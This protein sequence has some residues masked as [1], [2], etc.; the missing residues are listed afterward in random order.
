MTCSGHDLGAAY[1][2]A[3][4]TNS[5]CGVSDPAGRRISGA[6]PLSDP[7]SS[8][9]SNIPANNCPSLY[10]TSTYPQLPTKGSD[11]DLPSR[12]VISGT[13]SWTGTQVFCGDVQ[14]SGNVTLTGSN[15]TIVIQNGRLDLHGYKISTAS[16]AA[17]TI[18]FSGD[19]SASYSHYPV[20]QNFPNG[21]KGSG[22]AMIDITAPSGT[23]DAWRGIAMYQDPALTTNVSF[24]E[25]GNDPAWNIS[26]LAYFP[27]ADVGFTGIVSKA[28]NGTQCFVLLAYTITIGGTAQI[29]ANTQCASL[30]LTPPSV[31]VGT[32][33][34]V[35]LVS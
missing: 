9:A 33:A 18:V 2:V 30:G 10:P 11:P 1:G 28:T 12:N 17:A 20:N 32:S 26:G 23:S 27:K 22:P 4:G 25:A 24:A 21:T 3:V 5:G 8:R 15:T 35:K 16:G 14:L 6:T 13:K 34:R 31:T 19:N 7:Y 29:F